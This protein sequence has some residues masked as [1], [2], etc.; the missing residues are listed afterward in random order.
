MR[1]KKTPVPG[2]AAFPII[3]GST[4]FGMDELLDKSFEH[5]DAYRSFGGN[6]IDTA[7]VYGRMLGDSERAIG[8][9][10]R[11]R[12]CRDEII[13]GTKGGHPPFE[14]MH[15]GRLDRE[16]LRFDMEESLSNLGVSGVDVYY[17]H[18]DDVSRPVGD[19]LETLNGFVEEGKT[20]ILGASNWTA[21]RIREANDY[22]RAHGLHGFE[23]NQPMWSLAKCIKEYDDT[24][25]QMDSEL[26]EM[27]RQ[28]NLMCTPFSS[29]AKGY[30]MKLANGTLSPKAA[31]RYDG[32]ENR[33]IYARLCALSE[34]T[35]LSI[36]SL[37]LA[38]LTCQ[39]FPVFPIVGASS[40]AQIYELRAAAEAILTPAQVTGIRRM[41]A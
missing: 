34:E 12:K 6:W 20:K 29:Q 31:E 5:M 38:Y 21:A 28:E 27:H 15:S 24:L 13:I 16:N 41:D 9:W 3:L 23:A 22:A 26:W 35:G 18:R 1:Y 10:L 33:A 37:Q 8:A 25:V 17:L 39:E 7:R 2:K 19:I 40:A 11:E 32:D 30:F 14:N 4:A 36:A